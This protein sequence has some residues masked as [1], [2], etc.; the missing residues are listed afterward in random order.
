MSA[1]VSDVAPRIEAIQ[2]TTGER[3]TVVA[4]RKQHG[5][6]YALLDP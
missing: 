5:E 1:G 6:G 3:H 4:A 2:P